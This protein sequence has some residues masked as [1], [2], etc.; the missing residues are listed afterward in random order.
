MA[1]KHV[2]EEDF[3][4]DSQGVQ[5]TLSGWPKDKTITLE[6]MYQHIRARIAKELET[7]T[8]VAL[9]ANGKAEVRR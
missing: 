9:V 7:E 2:R 1:N 5:F 8:G 3:F 4:S 6:E